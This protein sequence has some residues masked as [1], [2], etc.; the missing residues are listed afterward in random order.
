[1]MRYFLSKLAIF[2]LLF[3][4]IEGATDV[5]VHGLPHSDLTVSE[6]AHNHASDQ[7]DVES[8]HCDHCCH[9]HLSSIA[10]LGTINLTVE[11]SGQTM[12]MTDEALPEFS[13]APPE[14]PP[15]PNHLS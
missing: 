7:L 11:Y 10:S 9:A 15:D 12:V 1:M 6:R 2:T 5:V 3:A 14:P 13:I 8:A 4:S